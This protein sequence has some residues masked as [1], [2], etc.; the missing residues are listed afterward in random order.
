MRRGKREQKAKEPVTLD[1]GADQMHGS[2]RCVIFRPCS[3]V[4]LAD[5]LLALRLTPG[6][7][8][9]C[10]YSASAPLVFPHCFDAYP[11]YQR[12]RRP[13]HRRTAAQRPRDPIHPTIPSNLRSRCTAQ[14]VSGGRHGP[15]PVCPSSR[16][17]Q[18]YESGGR[19]YAEGVYADMGLVEGWKVPSELLWA[20]RVGQPLYWPI[21][22]RLDY[23][24][25]DLQVVTLVQLRHKP[26]LAST[27]TSPA[28]ATGPPSSAARAEG[29]TFDQASSIVR[30]QAGDISRCV[31]SF[32]EQWERLSKVVVV[33]G[34]GVSSSLLPGIML[35]LPSQSTQQD[36]RFPG[37]QGALLRPSYGYFLLFPWIRCVHHVHARSGFV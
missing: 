2:S 33:A 37:H 36:R 4:V 20:S 21:R 35:R 16:S 26:T 24:L 12:S 6:I 3:I 8:K 32:L 19:G 14:R 22:F 31:P 11:S 27:G 1:L 34:E 7:S 30:F 18:G 13:D 5:I 10:S 25:T 17:T 9:T 29:I 15:D 23:E 28:S